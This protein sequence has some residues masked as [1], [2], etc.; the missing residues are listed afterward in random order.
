METSRVRFGLVKFMC[1]TRRRQLPP[2]PRIQL[3]EEPYPVLDG[4][5]SVNGKVVGH[6]GIAAKLM[7][8]LRQGRL[9]AEEPIERLLELLGPDTDLT[10]RHGAMGNNARRWRTGMETLGLVRAHLVRMLK[11]SPDI[12]P[13]RPRGRHAGRWDPL[14]WTITPPRDLA[15]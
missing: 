10:L 9:N 12:I 11:N 13:P 5:V 14:V 1:G 6:S 8:T 4:L 3:I 15:R 7:Q 2:V